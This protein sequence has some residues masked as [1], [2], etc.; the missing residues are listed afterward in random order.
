MVKRTPILW[1]SH[2]KENNNVKSSEPAESGKRNTMNK[3][4]A[5]A[6]NE[7]GSKGLGGARVENIA[8]EAGVT[9]Q[10]VYHYYG[11]KESLFVA[12][13]DESSESIMSELVALEIEQLAPP[14][15]LR[16]MLNRFFDQYCHDPLL[17][18]LALEGIRYHDA[19]ETPRNRFLEMAPGLIAKLDAIL[20]R[21]AATGDFKQGINPRL[22]LASAALV[23]TGW[24]TNRYSMS[25]LTGLDTASPEGMAIWRQHS[26][27]FILAGISVAPGCEDQASR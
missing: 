15:A 2:D 17:G 11:S 19:H 27:D 25:T 26:A 21:G 1:Q 4:L 9:K 3:L 7:F 6:R 8:Q 14:A 18:A 20:Q 24:F 13:L 10:L 12:V 16:A 5:A 23:T 22:L